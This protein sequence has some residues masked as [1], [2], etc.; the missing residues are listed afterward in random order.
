MSKSILP[1]YSSR[2]FR[3]S[4]LTFTYF[5]H[6]EFIFVY[7]VRECSNF[8]LLHVALQF[9]QDHLLKILSFSIVQSRLLCH[10]LIDHKFMGLPL[11]FLPCSI[12]LCLFLYQYHTVL[13]TIALQYSLKSGSLI[14]AALFFFL[15][16]AFAISG[17]LYFQ[18]NFKNFLLQLC[19][20]CHW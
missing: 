15:K 5:I 1:R 16:I 4:S 2:S 8:I 10:R 14:P 12:H 3:V 11:G 13:I 9:S 18:T 6:F 17:C 7:G 20:K 19:N